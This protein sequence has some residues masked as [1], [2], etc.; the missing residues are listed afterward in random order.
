MKFVRFIKR[1]K[2]NY[3]T[4]RLLLYDAI[5]FLKCNSTSLW[6]ER[7]GKFAERNI[8]VFCH[9]VEKGLSHKKLKPLFGLERVNMLSQALNDYVFRGGKNSFIICLAFSTI[10]H[11]NDINRK[12]GVPDNKLVPLPEWDKNMFDT[13]EFDINGLDVGVDEVSKED[14]FS[15]ADDH[16]S[17][18]C[19]ARHSVRLYD[20]VSDP[21]PIDIVEQAISVAQRSPSA[22]NRQAVR[23]R[24]LTNREL[25]R[26]I[27]DI[28]GGAK[29]FGNN[30]GMLLAIS[31]D[32]SL[33]Q[34]EERELPMLDCGL[35]IMNLLY[36]LY[37]QRLGTCVLNSSLSRKY[38]KKINDLISM[39]RNELIASLIAVSNIPKSESIMIAH[40]AKRNVED[41]IMDIR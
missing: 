11:Y 18:L 2:R 7:K 39:P 30:I 5:R 17:K 9:V 15:C 34:P 19:S 41:I 12:L 1:I 37:E 8:L 36:A 26:R 14:F 3:E 20:C 32:I 22:C 24:I 33:Y 38:E 23:V 4:M 6:A 10:K 25:I 29:G 28:Q 40:S 27:C 16:F 31:A 13:N 21:V 35:F